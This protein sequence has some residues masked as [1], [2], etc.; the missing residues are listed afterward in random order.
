MF[1]TV[2]IILS[3]LTL[4]TVSAAQSVA[5]ISVWPDGSALPLVGGYRPLIDP[6]G[7][8]AL[9][10]GQDIWIKDLASGHADRILT[11]RNLSG[12][13]SL[14]S[15]G[16]HLI[17]VASEEG[18]A[19]GIS[20][21]CSN[22]LPCPALY[23]LD[24]SSRTI[25]RVQPPPE[26]AAMEPVPAG[27]ISADLRWVV[28]ATP[29]GLLLYDRVNGPTTLISPGFNPSVSEDGRRILFRREASGFE[30]AQIAVYDHASGTIE[31]VDVGAPTLEGH[32]VTFGSQI[33]GDGRFAVF[34][35]FCGDCGNSIRRLFIRDLDWRRTWELVSG[36]DGS[37]PNLTGIF[38]RDITRDGR[39]VIFESAS[40]NLVPNDTSFSD[41]FVVDR[42][43]RRIIRINGDH[44]GGSTALSAST[45]ADG[46]RVV[47]GAPPLLLRLPAPTPLA[48]PPI[49]LSS[50]DIDNDGMQDD[51]ETFVGLSS[52]NPAD[53]AQDADFDGISNLDEFRLGS[54]PRARFQLRTREAN[55]DPE[56][57]R[58][59]LRN[60]GDTPASVW[61]RLVDASGLSTG[62]P[63]AVA[64][65]STLVLP[66]TDIPDRPREPFLLHVTTDVVI[67]P[68]LP[69]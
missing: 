8:F 28:Y 36:M 20:T 64:P 42:I 56:R 1:R 30:P 43:T 62:Y 35:A 54:Q 26:V 10:V 59:V 4:P 60:R 66:V 49:S 50:L 14:S 21:I 31:R 34:D 61:L 3:C 16:R 48:T 51:W 13:P 47:F 2:A 38:L 39:F 18:L 29:Q 33:S 19:P 11:L 57:A 68:S 46:L 37:P 44:R 7:R 24:L 52:A 6:N 69:Q 53:A 15:D 12:S 55:V 40:S 58:I 63:L 23:L 41:L 65:R 45:S 17:F 67:Y 32:S 27:T 9:F 5:R 25:V 22:R